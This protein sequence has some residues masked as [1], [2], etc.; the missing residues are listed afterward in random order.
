MNDANRDARH[1]TQEVAVMAERMRGYESRQVEAA[2]R[3]KDIT[4]TLRRIDHTLSAINVRLTKGD[5]RMDAIDTHLSVTDAQVEENRAEVV[6]INADKRSVAAV[7]MGVL[8][9]LG[10]TATAIWVGIKGG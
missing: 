2:A 5:A 7:V 6:A 4:E 10:A 1:S 9:T 3:D 8:S